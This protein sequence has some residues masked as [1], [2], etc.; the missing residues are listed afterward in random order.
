MRRPRR[1][2]R[3]RA[4]KACERAWRVRSRHLL[5][6]ALGLLIAHGSVLLHLALVSHA[7]CQ[8]GE[9]T[10]VHG[11]VRSSE[12]AATRL[13][14]THEDRAE[15]ARLDAAEHDHC[16]VIAVQ[17]GR[18]DATPTVA[19]ALMAPPVPVVSLSGRSESRPVAVLGLAPKSSPPVG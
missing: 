14:P 12:P 13:T 15:S 18:S 19:V 2:V 17:H 6:V 1:P 11:S 10:H 8:H 5:V 7:T 16:G 9:L 4:V 3:S